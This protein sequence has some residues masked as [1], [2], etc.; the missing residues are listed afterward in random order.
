VN[1]HPAQ[2]LFVPL[3]IQK[4]WLAVEAALVQEVL[5]HVPWVALPGMTPELP[6]LTQW[7][8]RTVVLL[9][10]GAL[11]EGLTALRPEETRAR[12]V[13]VRV[14]D[15]TIAIS[16][17]DVREVEE[18]EAPQPGATRLTRLR[19]TSEDA[20]VAA[21]PMPLLDLPSL[22]QSLLSRAGAEAS[23]NW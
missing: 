19:H 22:V 3:G 7:R 15:V 21:V 2:R 17:D 9:D 5:G 13:V 6:G 10:P 18:C 1:R 12:T 20:I 23:K 14:H 8:G 4:L 11:V 16:V